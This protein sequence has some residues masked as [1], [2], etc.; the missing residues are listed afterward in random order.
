MNDTYKFEDLEIKLNENTTAYVF[1][2]VE[3]TA[4]FYRNDYSDEFGVVE[5]GI[6]MD[7]LDIE[8]ASIEWFHA[9]TKVGDKWLDVGEVHFDGMDKDLVPVL[10]KLIEGDALLRE[11]VYEHVCAADW[12]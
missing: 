3:F 1:G 5:G 2:E 10:E 9:M 6:E 4:S 8:A 12:D 7:G 11:L